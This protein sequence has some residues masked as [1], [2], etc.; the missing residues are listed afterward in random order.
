MGCDTTV[1]PPHP[2]D[3][4]QDALFTLPDGSVP[5]TTAA[6][7]DDHIACSNDTCLPGVMICGHIADHARC[8]DGI[9]CNGAERCDLRM[10]CV[11]RVAHETCDDGNVC[12]VDRCVEATKMCEHLPR[13]LDL[14]GDPDF[15]CPGGMDCDDRD[16]TRSG[17]APEICDDMIDNDC[18]GMVDE[19]GNVDGGGADVGIARD[20]AGHPLC[21]RPMHDTC[22]DPIA[23]TMSGVTDLSLGGAS[24]DYTLSCVGFARPDLVATLTLTEAHDVTITAEG[25]L[26]TATV[27]LRSSCSDVATET[28]CNNGYPGVIRHRGLAAGTYFLIV[29]GSGNVILDVQLT[30]P[31]PP[32]ANES[33]TAPTVIPPTGGHFTGNFVD[34]HDDLMLSCNASAATDLVYQ[35]TL[36]AESNLTITLASPDGRYMNWSLRPTCG[37]SVGEVRCESGAPADS[38]L[39]QLPAGTY[40]IVIEGPSYVE[41]DYTLAVE[42]GPSTPRVM[43]DLCSNP[44]PLTLGTPYMG[45]MSG[46]ED[47]LV[48]SCGYNYRDLVHSF[49]LTAPSDVAITVD[50]GSAYLN[51]SL[52]TACANASSQL[53]CVTG[54][55]INS[56]LRAVP[57][58][59]YFV[60]VEGAR[61]GSYTLTV[62]ATT[63]PTVPTPASGNDVC[64]GAVAIPATGGFWTG[65]TIGMIN[66]YSPVRCGTGEPANDVAF[67]LDLSTRSRV[68]AN[69]EGSAFDTLL[70]RMLNTCVSG[71]E[72]VCDDDGGGGGGASQ[73]SEMLEPGTYFYIIDGFSTAAAGVYQFQVFVT[74]AP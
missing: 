13:D 7:C 40:F 24:A 6:D 29:Q 23:I 59:D 70:Y 49:T 42:V 41:V 15:F 45:T 16:P 28:D 26:A 35:I 14:D 30:D 54:A 67:R 63:P 3:A 21:G 58:G 69:T 57:A 27:A 64:G 19:G 34:L 73:L 47:D 20:D 33:C 71:M 17:L 10:D 39:H 44:I 8:D 48:T 38:T 25:D 1:V 68:T 72:V 11:H 61:V 51:A 56:H 22:M 43:G 31:T 53:R 18:D 62:T 12:S 66:N 46:A 9:F 60:I 37:S 52:R 50:G 32:P 36:A 55:P 4:G 5:C 65:T 2:M 74:P